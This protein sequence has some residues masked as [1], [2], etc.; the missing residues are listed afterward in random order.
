VASDGTWIGRQLH[1]LGFRLIGATLAVV[2]AGLFVSSIHTVDSEEKLLSSELTSLG[3]SLAQLAALYSPD[4]VLTSW[5]TSDVPVLREILDSLVRNQP[6]VM[7]AQ[8]R[9]MPENRELASAGKPTR[10]DPT[11]FREFRK[12]IYGPATDREG[13]KVIGQVVLGISTDSISKLKATR[14]RELLLQGGLCFVALALV[15]MYLLRRTVVGPVAALDRQATAL[16]QG[17]LDSPIRLASNDELGRLASTLDGMRRNLR[18]SYNEIRAANEELKRVGAAKDETMEQLAQALERANEASR[19]K[20]EF[21]AM[22]SHE[23]RTP[24]NGVIGMTELLLDAGLDTEQRELADTVRASAESLLLIVNDI[25]DFSKVD[26]KRMQLDIVPIELRKVVRGSFEILRSEA[27]SKGLEFT[28]KVDDDVPDALLADPLRLRQVLLNLLSNAVKFTSKGSVTLKV[29]LDRSSE[30]RVCV[31]FAV[32]DSGIGISDTAMLRLFK[33]FSQAD[34]SMSRKY[35]G[36]GLGLA[37][38]KHLAELMGG[39][40]GV[41][42]NEGRGSLFWF[43]S[44]MRLDTQKAG[45][46]PSRS[47][48]GIPAPLPSSRGELHD[49]GH[50]MAA[51]PGGARILLVEDNQVNQRLAVRMLQK[52]GYEVDVADNGFEALK[53][54]ASKPYDLIL[55]DCQMPEMDGFETTRRIRTAEEATGQHVLIV[56]MTANALPGDRERCI[57]A[58]MDEYIAKPVHAEMLYQLLGS[59]LAGSSSSTT[60]GIPPA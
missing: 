54:L 27:E 49:T 18:S 43:T 28:S 37:I 8:I 20:G 24:M 38:C 3:E 33:P 2:S 14:R 36:T 29:S 35:G 40:I 57:A 53:Q 30:D 23:I 15:L 1:R 25:L 21:L 58:G 59:V 41:E 52:R 39:E 44:Q 56:A 42:S 46:D 32:K 19:A 60:A 11:T 13:P 17:N 12:E 5:G 51:R 26:A 48:A 6:D 10:S 31:R 4:Y 7:F 34:T 45:E 22:M 16:G 55:M 9:R 50:R 47:P